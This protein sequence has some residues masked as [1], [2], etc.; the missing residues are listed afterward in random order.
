MGG[1]LPAHR[2]CSTR[3]NLA[4]VTEPTGA[5]PGASTLR[6]AVVL[7]AVETLGVAV[8]SAFLVYEDVTARA[9]NPGNAWSITGFALAVAI[10]M[11]VVCWALSRRRS[12]ARGPA[13]VLEMMLLPIGYYMIRGGLAWIGVPVLLLGLFGA[14]LLLAP[15][16]REALGI[17]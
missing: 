11:A 16:T 5:S 17:R 14:G 9:T 15:A 2:G 10:L 4:R 3:G 7:L 6:W 12:W 1:T 8:V 13:I